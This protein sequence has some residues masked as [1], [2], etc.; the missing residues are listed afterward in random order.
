MSSKFQDRLGHMSD[1]TFTKSGVEKDWDEK[2]LEEKYDHLKIKFYGEELSAQ[3]ATAKTFLNWYVGADM[4][5][6]FDL[7]IIL[8]KTLGFFN[9]YGK[10]PILASLKKTGTEDSMSLFSGAS[11]KISKV[12]ISKETSTSSYFSTSGHSILGTNIGTI[13]PGTAAPS[14]SEPVGETTKIDDVKTFYFAC[15]EILDNSPTLTETGNESRNLTRNIQQLLNYL[16]YLGL[17]VSRYSVKTQISVTNY[18][19]RVASKNFNNIAGANFS[20]ITP[21]PHS[22]AIQNV[23]QVFTKGSTAFSGFL[24][25]EVQ[26]YKKVLAI[27][28]DTLGSLLTAGNL[29]HFKF[30]GMLLLNVA[31]KLCLL[32]KTTLKQLLDHSAYS[33]FEGSLN[34]L[35][36]VSNKYICKNASSTQISFPWCR[37]I[38]DKY[39][40]S[41]SADPNK[42]LL[43]LWLTAIAELDNNPDVWSLYPWNGNAP[44]NKLYKLWTENL[45]KTI[46]P[47]SFIPL[48]SGAKT[49][50]ENVTISTNGRSSEVTFNDD[51]EYDYEVN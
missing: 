33:Q 20:W 9:D 29:L 31:S 15:W 22:R 8:L 28:D 3:I 32:S 43:D 36:D 51:K 19:A 2:V 48:T 10:S 37:L 45:K 13:M 12:D 50:M 42:P 14:N 34:R 41:L 1:T 18:F 5:P 40:T 24:I 46:E 27:E 4:G 38:D 16:G 39:M 35:I 30:N 47:E 25:T 7:N 26:L 21:P 17:I 23:V 49:F 44:R 6:N 11:G